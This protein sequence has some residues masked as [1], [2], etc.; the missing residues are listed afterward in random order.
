MH[1]KNLIDLSNTLI[2]MHSAIQGTVDWQELFD[3]VCKSLLVISMI[4]ILY[5]VKT[6]NLRR[7]AKVKVV[8]LFK[9]HLIL[10]N[11]RLIMGN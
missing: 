9:L 2:Y 1:S 10:L 5:S 8:S 6:C 3:G 11:L 4:N 7:I